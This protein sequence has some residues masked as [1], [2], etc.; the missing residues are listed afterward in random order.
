MLNEKL[1]KELTFKNF[2]SIPQIVLE[3]GECYIFK[4]DRNI[5][6]NQEV[7]DYYLNFLPKIIKQEV[8]KYRVWDDRYNCL[9]GKL[10]VF[11]GANLFNYNTFEFNKFRYT[12][13]G[14]PYLLDSPFH[15][16]ISHSGKTVVC[17]FSKHEIGVDIEQISDVNYMNFQSVFTQR[18]L[19]LI[20]EMGTDKFFELWTRKESAVKA[21]GKGMSIPLLKIEIDKDHIKH[22]GNYWYTKSFKLS[23]KNCSITSSHNDISLKEISLKF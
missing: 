8:L 15:F 2:R 5:T 13:F 22:A 3:E 20:D 4:Y 7:F 14:K 18:E 17:C 19:C 23:G 10:M 16:N 11:M 9:F 6:I 21:I 1:I 12:Y